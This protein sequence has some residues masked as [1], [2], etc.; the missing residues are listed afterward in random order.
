M[1]P[2]R[3][4]QSDLDLRAMQDVVIA[5]W[6]VDGPRVVVHIGDLAWWR[7]QHTGRESEWRIRLWDSG[8]RVAGWAWLQLPATAWL[9]V[10]PEHRR[11]LIPEIVSWL[12][13]ESIGAGADVLR[14]AACDNDLSTL[15]VFTDLGFRTGDEQPMDALSLRLSDEIVQA[16]LPPGYRARHVAGDSDLANRVAVHR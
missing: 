12:R 8:G 10:R 6:S 5:C 9:L 14:I 2:S 15:D 16:P 1:F 7:Y 3:E 13:S 11:T 4:Y